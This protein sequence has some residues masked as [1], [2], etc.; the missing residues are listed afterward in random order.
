MNVGHEGTNTV[1]FNNNLS[2]NI[3]P[4][5]RG[6]MQPPRSL[7]A[8]GVRSYLIRVPNQIMRKDQLPNCIQN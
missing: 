2:F 5:L 6:G 3:F 8:L 7:Y 4:D 1:I